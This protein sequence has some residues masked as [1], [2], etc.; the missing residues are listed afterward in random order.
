MEMEQV[1]KLWKIEES[2]SEFSLYDFDQVADATGNFSDDHKLGQ[3]G[4]G[5]VYRV[6]L[7]NTR[8]CTTLLKQSNQTHGLFSEVFFY[9]CVLVPGGAERRP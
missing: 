5:A 4:F 7:L 9:Y 3:G 1:L 6:Q 8:I 2:D